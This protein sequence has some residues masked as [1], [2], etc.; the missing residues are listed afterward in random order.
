MNGS[1]TLLGQQGQGYLSPALSLTSG[2]EWG[3]AVN[4]QPL[5]RSDVKHVVEATP[6]VAGTILVWT[7]VSRKSTSR[8][9]HGSKSR[10]DRDEICNAHWAPAPYDPGR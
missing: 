6:P 8:W 1:S 3:N 10:W 7:I 2:G 4:K 9:I 5:G